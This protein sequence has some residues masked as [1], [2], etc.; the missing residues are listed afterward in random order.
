MG[1]EGGRKKIQVDSKVTY[2]RLPTTVHDCIRL[3]KTA[4]DWLRL[5]TSVLI[6]NILV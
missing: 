1:D 6:A 2:V 4:Y 5:H 3:Y